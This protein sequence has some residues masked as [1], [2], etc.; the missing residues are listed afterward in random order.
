MSAA[1]PITSPAKALLD[2]SYQWLHDCGGQMAIA[3]NPMASQLIK[4]GLARRGGYNHLGQR[5]LVALG[6]PPK[7]KTSPQEIADFCLHLPDCAQEEAAKMAREILTLCPGLKDS[8]D[9]PQYGTL[10]SVWTD[11]IMWVPAF[12]GWD[13]KS[14]NNRKD[15]G[16]C[17]LMAPPTW[18]Y[19]AR[20]FIGAE[21]MTRDAYLLSGITGQINLTPV[22][23][24]KNLPTK[25]VVV[26][27][28]DFT[29]KTTFHS[30]EDPTP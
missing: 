8:R 29:W 26:I 28:Q 12:V 25:K 18:V 17:V 16:G 3:N 5:M 4:A 27:N 7:K 14:Y 10:Q 9:L 2:D 24:D 30:K 19:L 23:L 13:G 21:F 15:K 22:L 1:H 20:K 11:L 6:P